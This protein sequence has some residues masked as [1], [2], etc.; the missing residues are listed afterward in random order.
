MIIELEVQ[1]NYELITT[2]FSFGG[3]K[4][5]ATRRIEDGYYEQGKSLIKQLFITYAHPL[6]N[7]YSSLPR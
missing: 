7:N 5:V 1:I 4:S 6:H 3:G 2:I